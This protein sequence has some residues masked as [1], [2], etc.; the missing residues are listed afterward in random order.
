M[1]TKRKYTKW[2]FKIILILMGLLFLKVFEVFVLQRLIHWIWNIPQDGLEE[3]I[4]I[5]ITILIFVPF[6]FIVMHQRI[7]LERAEEKYKEL[8]YYDSITGLSNRRFFDREL[9]HSLVKQR[10]DRNTGAVLFLDIDGFKQVNDTFGHDVG[11]LL[12]KEIGRRLMNCVGKEGTVS[13]FAGDEFIILFPN[14]A[15][16]LVLEYVRRIIKEISMPFTIIENI[17]YTSTSVGIAFFP[18][19]GDKAMNLIKNADI[20]MYK[21]KLQG[22][23]TYEIF[24]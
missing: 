21:A 10:V 16:P 12:L 9:N 19:H 20:A 14:T 23:N 24:S 17:I 18:E 3:F 2:S 8:A 4:D 13:R 6:L 1:K 15:K 5:L 7:T 22:K 11:D